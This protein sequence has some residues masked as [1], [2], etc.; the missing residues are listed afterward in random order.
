MEE[1][2]AVASLAVLAPGLRP[3][4]F[5]APVDAGPQGLMPGAPTTPLGT[6]QHAGVDTIGCGCRLWDEA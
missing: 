2:A 6:L 5:R 1:A 3:R 4:I